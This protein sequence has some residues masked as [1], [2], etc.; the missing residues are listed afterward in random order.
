MLELESSGSSHLL[1]V[2]MTTSP[3]GVTMSIPDSKTIGP[4]W[5]CRAF[6]RALRGPSSCR[7]LDSSTRQFLSRSCV[8]Q[9]S[10]RLPM[11]FRLPAHYLRAVLLLVHTARL[12]DATT[13]LGYARSQL[14]ALLRPAS[15]ARTDARG[16]S[17]RSRRV[18]Q[19]TAPGR[20]LSDAGL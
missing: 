3:W 15:A 13:I 4:H 8:A 2:V 12:S 14:H 7:Y 1:L 5:R 17:C 20:T 18:H 16:L 6:D 11:S 19:P 10:G 9:L